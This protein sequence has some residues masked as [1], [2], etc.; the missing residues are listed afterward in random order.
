MFLILTDLGKIEVQKF[1]NMIKE[2]QHQQINEPMTIKF[3][4]LLDWVRRS[5]DF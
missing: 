4:C 1:P 5:P 3:M 2:A